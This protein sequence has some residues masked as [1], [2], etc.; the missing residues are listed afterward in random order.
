MKDNKLTI[1]INKPVNEVFAF[2][3]NPQNTPLW[4]DGIIKE[5]T[6]IW[7]VK[8]GTKYKNQ[9]L[10][11]EWSE[12]I[13]SEFKENEMFVLDKNDN[14]YHVKYTFKPVD[15]NITEFEYYEWVDKGEVEDPFTMEVL[16]KL[17]QILEN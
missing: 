2:T 9:N 6:D 17:K 4:I 12:Y 10:K 1:Q 3:I 8:Q 5:E 7:P 15:K 11:G 14:N 13:V 16:K